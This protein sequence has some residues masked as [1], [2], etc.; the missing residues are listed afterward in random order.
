MTKNE[1]NT[2]II[3]TA[4]DRVEE[5]CAELTQMVTKMPHLHIISTSNDGPSEVYMTGKINTAAKF[6]IEATKHVVTQD[7]IMTKLTELS[8]DLN[9]KI[10]I[11]LPLGDPDDYP[12]LTEMLDLIHPMQDVDGFKVPFVDINSM[13]LPNEFITHPTFSPTAK[14]V[15]LLNMLVDDEIKGKE[16]AI[17][18]KGLTSGLPI[19]T[20]YNRLGATVY[21]INSR[22]SDY[23]KSHCMCNSEI[24]VSCAGADMTESLAKLYSN[25][26]C[27][28][29][30]MR[31][32]GNKLLGDLDYDKLH[33]HAKFINPV[34][35]STGKLT[36][37]F[38]IYNCLASQ[39]TH[40]VVR[41]NNTTK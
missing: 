23:I 20:M 41:Y 27:I 40:E 39:M 6:G 13:E 24:I 18:G 11:Q 34:K 35:G 19:S 1:F 4:I 30:G 32:E 7:T 2:N 29:V 22:T 8:K 17:V 12:G 38:L 10:I 31:K 25:K 9:N 5:C 16:V 26:I 3:N 37:L 36:T 14:G 21:N 28:N 33:E 15:L